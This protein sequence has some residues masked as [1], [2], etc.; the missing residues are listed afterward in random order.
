MSKNSQTKLQLRGSLT[1]IS[2]V[3][4]FSSSCPPPFTFIL[5][6]FSK[7]RD[8]WCG[9]YFH[10]LVYL[11]KKKAGLLNPTVIFPLSIYF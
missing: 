5:F 7:L 11:R 8:Y 10:R 1:A 9:I 4:Y 2:F 6:Y 3:H